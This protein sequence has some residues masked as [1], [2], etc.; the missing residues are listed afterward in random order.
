M[1]LERL[2]EQLLAVRIAASKRR[3]AAASRSIRGVR[4]TG[5]PEQ[6]KS[7][8]LNPAG[9][10]RFAKALVPVLATL[11]FVETEPDAFVPEEGFTSLFNGRDLTGWD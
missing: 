6:P 5:L 4:A 1:M 2:G 11:G 7:S 8:Q 9:Y 3:P 10:D